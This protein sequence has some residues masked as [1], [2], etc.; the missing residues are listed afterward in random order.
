[1]GLLG[2]ES[3]YY[4]VVGEVAVVVT[5]SSSTGEEHGAKYEVTFLTPALKM[6]HGP[7]ETQR[8]QSSPAGKINEDTGTH[9]ATCCIKST[10]SILAPGWRGTTV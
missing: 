6:G 1:M 2:G 4:Y 10:N 8:D 5:S 7:G 9:H 3:G